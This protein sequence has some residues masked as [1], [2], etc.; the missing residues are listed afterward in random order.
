MRLRTIILLAI[1]ALGISACHQD[2]KQAQSSQTIAERADEPQ[3]TDSPSTRMGVETDAFYLNQVDES[4]ANDLARFLAGKAV[5]KYANLQSSDFYKD[6][7]QKCQQQWDELNRKTLNPIQTWCKENINEFHQ[8][9]SCLFYPFGGPDMIF[10]TTFFPNEKDYVLMGLENPGQLADPSEI[11][12]NKLHAYLDSLNYSFRYLNRFGFFIAGQMRDDFKNE[13]LDGTLHLV[14]YVLAMQNSIIT[15]YRNIYIDDRGEIKESDGKPVKH[16]YGWEIVFQKEG[17]S[18]IRTVKYL[19]MDLSDP[20]MTGKME[21]PFFLN[22]YKQKT[23]YLK[24]ASYLLQDVQFKIIQKL[25][26]DQ[27]DRILQDESGLAYGRLLHDYDVNLFGTY[28]RP[29]KVFSIFKQEDLKAAL[30]NS[31]PLPFKIGYASQLNE[32]VLMACTRKDPEKPII[33][34]LDKP[35]SAVVFTKDTIYRVQFKVSWKKLPDSELKGLKDVDY[36]TDNSSYKYVA[37]NFKNDKECWEY[38]KKVREMGYHD[39]FI[40]KFCNGK[41][42]K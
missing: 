42:I 14:L 31:K 35:T 40:V 41:R 26:V 13:H 25:V 5:D 19:R 20:P 30:A 6:Y 22:S 8:D 1:S 28:T 38:V 16:P 23:C 15:N 9:S 7:A 36:Y 12:E 10:A 4:N 3:L 33:S 18:K 29:L 39:A 27:F 11:S 17:D 21:F 24:S 37:G 32:S 2:S 34:N